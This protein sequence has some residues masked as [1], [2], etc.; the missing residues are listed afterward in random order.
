VVTA[1]PRA[2]WTL[3]FYFAADNDLEAS[4]MEDLE[5]LT[6]LPSSPQ[7]R[8]LALVDRSPVGEPSEGYSNRAVAN[9]AN[10]SHA[11]LLEVGQD[12]LTELEDWGQV[13]MADPQSLQRFI[14][15]AQ[16]RYPAR[17]YGLFLVDHG[18]SWAGLCSDDSTSQDN[19]RLDLQEL[20]A[21]LATLKSPLDLL[22]FDACMM[23]TLEVYLA[24][25]P[26]ARYLVASQDSLPAQGLDYRGALGRLLDRPDSDGLQ[27]G[28]WFLE[29]YRQS[30]KRDSE[31]LSRLQLT[32][33]SNQSAPALQSAFE[34][35]A[36]Q[37]RPQVKKH[38]RALALARASAPSFH[39]EEGHAAEVHDLGQW[40]NQLSQRLPGLDRSVGAVRKQLKAAVVDQVRGRFRQ[41]C[42]G[43]SVFFPLLAEHLSSEYFA[44]VE[45]LVGQWV[46][47]LQEYTR[48]ER[49]IRPRPPLSEV[50]LTGGQRVELQA[51]L[52]AEVAA[53]YT[54]LVQDQRLVGQMTC[55]PEQGSTL[56]NDY[57]DG[58]WLSLREKGASSSILAHLAAVEF[59]SPTSST[60]LATLPCNL[61]RKESNASMDVQLFFSLHPDDL[62]SPAPLVG[63]S[64]SIG[65]GAVEIHLQPGDQ[66]S[67]SQLDLRPGGHSDGGPSLQLVQPD[68]L[69]LSLA[70]V[71]AGDYQLGFLVVDLQGRSHWQTRPLLW[72]H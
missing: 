16:E 19:D 61:K 13:S 34:G 5:E 48:L 62:V 46:G 30:L 63:V 38:W 41:N 70:P 6:Q 56:L 52:G 53:S 3:L 9:L 22:V 17:H 33:L 28:K 20:Q 45:P 71:P 60:A 31:E 1:Q 57:F 36:R 67:F 24:A 18:Q 50:T 4:E 43:L 69:S 59:E 68:A 47:F 23:S 44:C 27:L 29:G 32:L 64:R 37:L 40:L 14:Q 72:G 35:L 2:Q 15:L 25:A 51:R 21:S 49:T 54:I 10:W 42:S 58:R 39:G 66:L 8:M 12:K 11:K 7:V 55:V 26:H 65:L